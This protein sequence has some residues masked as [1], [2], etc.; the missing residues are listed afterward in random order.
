SVASRSP[1]RSRSR[2]NRSMRLSAAVL[3][4]LTLMWSASLAARTAEPALECF[5]LSPPDGPLVVSDRAECAHR[6]APASTFKLPHALIALDTGVITPA[7][8]MKWD[9][10]RYDFVSWRRDHT[11]E[12]AI[13]SSVYPFFR[14]TAT[15]IGRERMLKYLEAFDYGSKTYSGD[16]TTFWT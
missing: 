2:S 14:R 15:L 1:P 7:T 3:A 8:V 5:V 4:L 12:T 16:Q 10:T 13:R 9:G 11:L 6:T